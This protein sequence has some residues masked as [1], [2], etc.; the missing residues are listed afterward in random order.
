MAAIDFGA[1][2]TLI[3]DDA[4]VTATVALEI[5]QPDGLP[6]TLTPT[7]SPPEASFTP[8]LA[9]RHVVRW[10][11][12]GA[13]S[14]AYTDLLDVWPLDPRFLISLDDA[15]NSLNAKGRMPAEDRED[16]R[17]Y[18]AAATP[19][20]EDI[21]GPVLTS[22]ETFV[23]SGGT[24][25]VVLPQIPS[26][27]TAIA[28]NGV[29][30]AAD[31]WFEEAGIVTAGRHGAESRFG[32]G[33]LVVNYT[34]GMAA[35]PPNIRLGT[36]ELVRHWWQIGK[37]ASG[38]AVRGQEYQADAFTPSGFAVPRRVIELCAPHQ[39]VGGFA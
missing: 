5:I 20:I 3:W 26:S 7:G 19:V 33:Q 4:P 37:Q 8:A 23:T 14:D 16:L 34:V 22:P 18:I 13:A 15:E 10:S 21:V 6:L 32:A 12:S 30:L 39:Q 28:V 31:E 25:T 36:R 17:L 38:G 9:G 11:A 29:S 24:G 1:N 35:V 2:V 27:I